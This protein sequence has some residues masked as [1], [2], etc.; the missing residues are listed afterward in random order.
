MENTTTT[1]TVEVSLQFL[2]DVLQRAAADLLASRN[3]LSR[4]RA[5]IASGNFSLPRSIVADA[6]RVVDHL[7]QA[8]YALSSVLASLRDR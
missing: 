2:D 6:D 7:K 1:P 8:D 3:A 4:A 5:E